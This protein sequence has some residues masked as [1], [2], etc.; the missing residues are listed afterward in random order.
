MTGTAMTEAGE[1]LET[2]N[3]EVTETTT[4]VPTVRKDS[5]DE[6]YRTARE[7]YQSILEQARDCQQRGQPILVGTVS[8]EKSELLSAGLK[9]DG[10]KYQVLNARHHEQEAVISTK[11]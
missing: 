5:D 2:Y 7:K 1:F 11:A 8:K 6:V 9:K 10:I 3:L 4:N